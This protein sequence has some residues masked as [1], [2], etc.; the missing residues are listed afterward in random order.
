MDRRIKALI[1]VL[2]LW[3]TAG[4]AGAEEAPDQG[5]KKTADM[6]FNFNQ[7]SYSDSWA[8]D[9]L[10][11]MNWT[12]VANLVAERNLSASANWKNDL[13]LSYGQTH[14][15]QRDDAGDKYWANPEKSS[16]R[17]FLESLLRFDLHRFI[18]PYAAATFE[19]QFHDAADNPLSPATITESLG[20][21]HQIMKDDRGEIFTRVGFALRQ[22]TAYRVAGK[23][24]GGLE[25][26][27]DFDRKF[28]EDG[29]LKIVS[30]LRVFQAVFSSVSDDLQGLEN[31]DYWK[32]PD[33]AWETTLSAAVTKLIQTS[34]FVEFLY[35]KEIS[36]QG[37]YRQ[38]LGL[39]VT[40]KLF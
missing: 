23:T 24:S 22:E 39:G 17:I 18:E 34:L 11:A 15:Q 27:T 3:T 12:A 40:Y 2:A 6:G 16:D 5:W 26:V 10:G 28:G 29:D 35:D 14:Q 25:W 19:S 13:K 37:R 4:V 32:S 30:K 31:E 20:G 8:G 21:G 1:I 7:S 9:E 38:I 36:R 33:V